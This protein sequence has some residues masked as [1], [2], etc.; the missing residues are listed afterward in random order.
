MKT[1]V[2]VNSHNI[3][4][5]RK[6]GSSDKKVLTVKTY[7]SNIK[8]NEV[9]VY[10]QDGKEAGR[11]VYKPENPLPCGAVLWY[12]TENKVEVV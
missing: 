12:E 4:S 8:S 5:N 3:R 10:G 2:H 11:F 7:K 6:S 1:K 9:I